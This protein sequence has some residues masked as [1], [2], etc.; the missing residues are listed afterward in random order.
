MGRSNGRAVKAEE[1]SLGTT[2]TSTATTS[3]SMAAQ[4]NTPPGASSAVE[5]PA[6][7]RRRR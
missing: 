6:T 7:F 1:M 5:R 4:S 3:G 2:S